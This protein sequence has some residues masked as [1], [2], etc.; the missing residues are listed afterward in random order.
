MF[1]ALTWF[2]SFAFLALWSLACW[3]LHT[4]TVWAVAS[5]GAL[6]GGTAAMG[7]VFIPGWLSAWIPPELAVEFQSLITSLA[8]MVQA[9][10]EAVPALSGT[11]TVLAWAIWGL[12]AVAL[13]ALAVGAH[14]LIAVLKRRSARPA[15]SATTSAATVR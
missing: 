9:A 2:L 13:L 4:V 3:G 15:D 12:G 5:A 8:P 10:L 14:V 1:Y 7:A 6:A 11:V